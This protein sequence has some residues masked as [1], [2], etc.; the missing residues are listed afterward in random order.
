MDGGQQDTTRP[1]DLFHGRAQGVAPLA[2]KQD[3]YSL[4]RRTQRHCTPR[5]RVLTARDG[6]HDCE[7]GDSY[8]QRLRRHCPTN[9]H[10]GKPHGIAY[11]REHQVRRG[12]TNSTSQPGCQWKTNPGMRSQ[13]WRRRHHTNPWSSKQRRYGHQNRKTIPGSAHP[14]LMDMRSR[15]QTQ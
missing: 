13:R 8:G 7:P 3:W 4:R 9:D 12:I 2:A 11:H 1:Q 15:M 10:G 5:Q 14:L 6:G